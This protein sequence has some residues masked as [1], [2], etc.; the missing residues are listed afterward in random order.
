[1]KKCPFCG[2]NIEESARFCLYCMQSL[3]EKE[4]IL[5][6]P[7]KKPQWLLIIAAIVI[8]L[9]MLA[10]A[11]FSSQP[12]PG[13]AL[14]SEAPSA[15]EQ[16]HTP[17]AAVTENAVEATCT[18]MGSY[19]EVVYCSECQEEISRTQKTVEKNPHDYNQKVTTTEYLKT[20][21]THTEAAVYYYSCI[22]G[23]KGETTFT[24]GTVIPHTFDQRSTALT[25]QKSPA[26]CTEF[27]VYYFP[28]LAEKRGRLHLQVVL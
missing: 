7:K 3:T 27:A 5:P 6:H 9:L 4:Q 18:E 25:Y 14:P 19:D 23:E 26:T 12:A 21:A 17:A 24:S 1:M 2:A 13:N 15:T 10:V 8:A 16:T 22:C 20:E 28:A 11:W